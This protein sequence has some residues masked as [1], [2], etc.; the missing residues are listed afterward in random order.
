MARKRKTWSRKFECNIL[1]VYNDARP[2]EREA[3]LH[4]YL[5]ANRAAAGIAERYGITVEQSAGVIAALSPGL[6][7]GLNISHADQLIAAWRE[8]KQIPLV[9]TY[10]WNNIRKAQRILEGE[11]PAE[12]LNSRTGPKTH[13]FYHCI[14]RPDRSQHVTIDRHAACLA[15]YEL[16]DRKKRS[17]V[18]IHQYAFYAWHY[19]RIAERLG[20]RPHQLQAITW[21]VWK[22]IL[23]E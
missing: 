8:G 19:K 15:H 4:W 7:W 12:V 6:E 23:D 18:S 5:N 11:N 21:T 17:S 13:A 22:R 9:G 10:G 20:L 2:E 1:R 3:G 16:F 14:A